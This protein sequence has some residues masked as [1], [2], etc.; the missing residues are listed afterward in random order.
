ML[1]VTGVIILTQEGQPKLSDQR[2]M[3]CE[4]KILLERLERLSTSSPTQW[5]SAFHQQICPMAGE[6]VMDVMA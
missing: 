1:L 5:L 2:S 6:S 3:T 4:S